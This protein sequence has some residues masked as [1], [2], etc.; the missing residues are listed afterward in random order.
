[1][2]IRRN[3]IDDSLLAKYL[4]GSTT[5]SESISVESWLAENSENRKEFDD[6]KNIWFKSQ[7]GEFN[8]EI[9]FDKS[10]AFKKVLSRIENDTEIEK[11]TK[12]FTL[13][14]FFARAAAVLVLGI[15]SY[16]VYQ[17]LSSNS[18]VVVS[19]TNETREILMPDS[20]VINL[21][22]ESE[23]KYAENFKSNRTLSLKGE[24]F[25]EVKNQNDNSFI[26][27][28]NELEVKVLGTSFYVRAYENDSLI[29]VGVKT[30]RVEVAQK[31]GEESIILNANETVQYNKN[32]RS[33]VKQEVFNSNKLFWKTAVLEFNE[34]PLDQVLSTLG[35]VY[36]TEI[37]FQKSTLE[38]CNFTGRFKNASL[39]EILEQLQFSFNIEVA[40]SEKV[41]ITGNACDE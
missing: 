17:N 9:S 15:A 40:M 36:E 26:V 1:M 18:E 37:D 35:Q 33:F 28:A 32:K 12:T 4:D 11:P 20:S 38:N 22:A 5:E 3:N 10:A 8:P 7:N 19:A 2:E 13:S 31:S 24:A 25:F 27:Q 39:E 41:V 29:E 14:T 30:G 34:Q 23:I 6:F 21:D 16:F